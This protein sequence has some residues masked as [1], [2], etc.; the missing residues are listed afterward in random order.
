M[1]EKPGNLAPTPEAGGHG[2]RAMVMLAAILAMWFV[3]LPADNSGTITAHYY[4]IQDRTVL[5]FM[6]L[7]LFTLGWW[8][9]ALRLTLPA[10]PRWV[11]W[12]AAGALAGLLWLGTY[13]VMLDYPLT[14]DE[15]MVLFDARNFS[16]GQL[17]AI[18]PGQWVGFTLALVPD[19][20]LDAPGDSLLAS[21]YGPGNAAMRAGFGLLLDPALMNPLLAGMGLVALV[22]IAKRQ[23]PDTPHAVW[24]CGLAYILSAQMLVAAMTTYA[25]TAHMALNLVWLALFL[26][27]SR[28]ALAGTM[29]IG[30]WAIGLHQIIFHLRQHVAKV[31]AQ[32]NANGG[33]VQHNGAQFLV[34]QPPI[35]NIGHGGGGNVLRDIAEKTSFTENA[36]WPQRCQR[37]P[38]LRSQARKPLR[39]QIERV[40][41]FTGAKKRFTGRQAAFCKIVSQYAL[42]LF[43]QPHKE[44][45]KL[46]KVFI[47]SY[48]L[49]RGVWVR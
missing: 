13:A 42:I 17:A 18:V 11:L 30:A 47:H 49:Q 48:F 20:L 43:G 25:M 37:L 33:M 35:F 26:R 28:W 44:R 2:P 45:C 4:R 12:G 21:A 15:H 41:L 14:R 3:V 7:A 6:A 46:N 27:G 8:R 24:V 29:V 34:G 1:Q 23:F 5:G 39:Q 38:A 36:A 40:T 32:R 19:F 9:P 10:M 22:N 31:V 16:Q